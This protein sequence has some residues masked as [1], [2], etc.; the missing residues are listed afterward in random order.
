MSDAQRV[1]AAALIIKSR[2]IVAIYTGDAARSVK[3]HADAGIG[4]LIL[5]EA[6]RGQGYQVKA[7]FRRPADAPV[8]NNARVADGAESARL[9]KQ[10]HARNG[11][12]MQA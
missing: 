2:W 5:Q 11:T 10:F 3:A 9:E 7:A 8:P 6:G 4:Y 1:Q 12:R